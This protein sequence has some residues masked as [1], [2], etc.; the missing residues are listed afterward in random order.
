MDWCCNIGSRMG[1]LIY[2]RK[3]FR[4]I[5]FSVKNIRQY[6]QLNCNINTHFYNIIEYFR[7]Q[8]SGSL[9]MIFSQ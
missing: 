3:N 5:F 8:F 9:Q 7:P 6:L 1:D 4:T 2:W